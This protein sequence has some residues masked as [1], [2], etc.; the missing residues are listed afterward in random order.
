MRKS[1]DLEVKEQAIKLVKEG[2]SFQEAAEMIGATRP[3]VSKWWKQA[4]LPAMSVSDE[5]KKI[6]I[7]AW[8]GKTAAEISRETN[9][10]Y[11]TVKRW[12]EEAG[13]TLVKRN[14]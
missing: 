5:K 8:A 14:R 12:C 10:N 2:L 9:R 3:V 4:G 1:Y 7:L 13:I 6:Y 11:H